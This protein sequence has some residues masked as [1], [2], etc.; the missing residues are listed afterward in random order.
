[1]TEY[2]SRI[3]LLVLTSISEAQ[4]LVILEAGCA[5]IPTVASDVGSCRELLEGR[6]KEDR[7]LG[8]S[9]IVTRVSDPTKTAEAIVAI[10]SNDERRLTMA[11]AAWQR[12]EA[13]YNETD[14][15]RDYLGLYREYCDAADVQ[16][17]V[18]EKV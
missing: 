15:N 2:Y 3:D 18:A 11:R 12:V 9:G 4:P 10:L 17:T 13:Y 7:D 5:G 14:L 6:T 16:A 8:P 1:M